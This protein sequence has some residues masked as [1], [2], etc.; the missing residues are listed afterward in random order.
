MPMP[1]P[2]QQKEYR[3]R[4]CEADARIQKVEAVWDVTETDWPDPD[5]DAAM[6]EENLTK[7]K[8]EAQSAAEWT[9]FT[10][11][12]LERERDKA[13]NGRV[14]TWRSVYRRN[15]QITRQQDASLEGELRGLI[16][17]WDAEKG[18][19]VTIYGADGVGIERPSNWHKLDQALLCAAPV[20][21]LYSEV[22]DAI[23]D[24]TDETVVW[25][26]RKISND[27]ITTLVTFSK[28]HLRPIE[29]V[30]QDW[31]T[32]Q[33]FTQRSIEGYQEVGGGAW[34]P[35]RIIRAAYAGYEKPRNIVIYE[36]TGLRLN[37]EADFPDLRP[38]LAPG[39]RVTDCRFGQDCPLVYT[40]KGEL[41]TDA[42]AREMLARQQDRE[43]RRRYF[44]TMRTGLLRPSAS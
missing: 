13:A 9:T 19:Y 2:L 31:R 36:L 37:D 27:P 16:S 35:S 12:I 23:I 5:F 10:R 38:S 21:A 41:P 7:Q 29:I 8:P 26:R 22:D 15:G 3:Q 17:I 42:Q 28:A 43:R 30:T 14:A 32:G 20:S 4:I 33:I 24:E 34:F 6:L 40:L 25:E 18:L 44:Q 11:E 1:S 39:T